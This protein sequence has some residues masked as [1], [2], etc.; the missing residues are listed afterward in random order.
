MEIVYLFYAEIPVCFR[1][2]RTIIRS[3]HHIFLALQSDDIVGFGSSPTYWGTPRQLQK[4]AWIA[5]QWLP[6]LDRSNA[7]DEELLLAKLC[8]YDSGFAN[9]LD[10]ALWDLRA[11]FARKSLREFISPLTDRP[12]LVTE[13]L[14]IEDTFKLKAQLQSMLHRGTRR[15]KLKCGHNP[16]SD[17]AN[18]R[19]IRQVAGSDMRIQLDANSGYTFSQALQY[20]EQFAKLG[21][22]AWEDPLVAADRDRYRELRKNGPLC[23]IRDADMQKAIDVQ[24]ALD[25]EEIDIL[26][27]KLNRV[28]GISRAQKLCGLLSSS[29]TSISVGC[30]EDLGPA[31]AGIDA[32]AN[33]IPNL[34]GAEALGGLRLGFDIG[35]QHIGVKD[36]AF[37]PLKGPGHGIE[38]KE[39]L[40]RSAS[41]K[42]G[43]KLYPLQN[44]HGY[45][46]LQLIAARHLRRLRN[47]P[48][49]LKTG[50]R[51]K[52]N[53]RTIANILP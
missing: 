43:F 49:R 10:I 28:G 51:Q 4:A 1:M 41:A 25:R 12:I 3:S 26:S 11:K 37:F 13:Q 44:L 46:L 21:V 7:S 5:Q 40:L 8:E 50:V 9:A 34:Y 32:F 29:E 31:M 47:L 14:F 22:D 16:D 53:E 48:Y 15:V 38:V 6:N 39:S 52:M 24:I 17:L 45:H 19:V 2:S 18:V 33:S 42:R 20:G 35:S 23:I 36:G 27:I 30:A